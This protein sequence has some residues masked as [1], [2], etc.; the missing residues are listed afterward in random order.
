MGPLPGRDAL[1]VLLGLAASAA[2]Q[3]FLLVVLPPLG[4]R[5]GFSDI[6]TG[7][8]LSVSALLL[9]VCAPIWGY[10][11]ERIGRRKVMLIALAGASLGPAAFSVIVGARIG[12]TISAAFALI[13]LFVSR[14]VQV[15]VSAGLL[16]AAQ[17]YVADLTAPSRRA[18]GMGLIGA[19]FG[20][21]VVLGATLAWKLGGKDAVF[22]FEMIAALVAVSFAGVFLLVREPGR[23]E[24]KVSGNGLPSP[25]ARIWPFLAITLLGVTAYAILQQVT[26]LRLQDA[27]G[28]SSQDSIARAGAALMA[29]ALAMVVVQGLALR[30]LA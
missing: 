12:E 7:A 11:S 18:G 20:G 24:V 4:R 26:A 30:V 5:L 19:A 10:V 23:R 9:I 28:F 29:T 21:G 15:V 2:G 17:A 6:E 27:L 16:P 8:I 22:V 13:L 1:P 14:S 25:L 3:S